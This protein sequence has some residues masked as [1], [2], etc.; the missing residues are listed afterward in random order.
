MECPEEFGY[1]RTEE[2]AVASGST[3]L[4]E[5]VFLCYCHWK[6]G[7]TPSKWESIVRYSNQETIYPKPELATKLDICGPFFLCD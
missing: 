7:L 4:M 6:T 5:D 1:E 2:T 3:R